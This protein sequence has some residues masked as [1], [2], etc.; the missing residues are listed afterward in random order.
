MEKNEPIFNVPPAVVACIGLLAAVHATLWL[1]PQGLSEWWTFALAFI[2]ARYD[3][4]SDELPGGPLAM[5]TSFFT[6]MLVHGDITHL[7]FN[8]AWLLAF[9]GAVA[10]RIGSLRFVLFLLLCGFAGATTF[11]VFNMGL[12]APMV[13]A[14]GAISGLMGG[15][16]RFLF[17][18]HG[19][20]GLWQLRHA[21]RTIPLMP[22]S[23]TLRDRRVLMAIA[24][25]IGVNFLALF[26][27]GGPVSSGGIAWEA[28]I[29]GFFAGLLTFGSFEP[30]LN[31][32]RP[33]EPA[34]R[35]P[36]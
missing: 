30:P 12:A 15:V 5:V 25:W 2:P 4:Y 20:G 3:G 22:L 9:G 14:S 32:N 29:G 31:D 34:E 24:I 27:I 16:F 7:G 19:P 18:V 21:P 10:Q 28:H 1:L 11:L 13:G 26:G 36:V 8:A 23:E 33:M 17:N 35:G 6:H